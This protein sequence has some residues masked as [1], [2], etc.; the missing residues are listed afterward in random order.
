MRYTVCLLL[1]IVSHVA[2]FSQDGKKQDI[3]SKVNGEEMKGNVIEINDSTIRFSYTGETAIYTIKKTE[4]AQITFASGRIE[5]YNS[6]TVSSP[7]ASNPE[8]SPSPGP[9]NVP[10]SLP[11]SGASQAD[12]RNKIAILPFSFIQDGQNATQAVSEQVQN[13]C[14]ALLSKHSGVYKVVS[15]RAVNVRM[16]KA[17]ITKENMLNYTMAEMCQLLGVEYILEG[18]ITQNKTTQTSYGNSTYSNKSKEND[19][20]TQQKSSGYS[21]NYST[22]VQNYETVMD[23][24]IYNDKSEIVYDQNRKAFWKTQDAYKNTMEY[25]VKRC[26]LYK[27]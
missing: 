15:P 9:S 21:S 5:K 14:Y 18:M 20:A 27:K 16:N 26:P 7:A 13:E 4:I 17:G 19:N 8:T 2:V 12:R 22:N 23:M 25:L 10:A 11:P 6:P 24:K 1:A 3:V